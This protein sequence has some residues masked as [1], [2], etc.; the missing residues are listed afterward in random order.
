MIQLVRTT[1][2]EGWINQYGKGWLFTWPNSL[3]YSSVSYVCFFLL[4]VALDNDAAGMFG[5][6][7]R[8]PSQL[9]YRLLIGDAVLKRRLGQ[10]PSHRLSRFRFTR[11]EWSAGK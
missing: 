10:S 5:A 1:I 3:L 11:R 2:F 4:N 7:D 9:Q 8:E 6:I